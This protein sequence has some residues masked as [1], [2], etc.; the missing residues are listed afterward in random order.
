MANLIPQVESAKGEV[1]VLV[2]FNNFELPIGA[3]RQQLIEEAKGEYVTMVDDD[4]DLPDDYVSTILPLLDGVDYI[5]F[6][7]KF[8]HNG[9]SMP[10]VIHSLQ[11][12]TWS[13]DDKGYYRGVTHLNPTRRVLALEAGYPL[14]R[15]TGEDELWAKKVKAETE[16]FIDKEMYIYNHVGE[17]SYAYENRPHP[18]PVTP[19]LHSKYVRLHPESTKWNR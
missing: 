14:E 19:K 17:D 4:D 10:P 18:R 11:Y 2:H 1:E 5:G 8:I 9:H 16:H 3:V 13:Q 7:V 15:V 6:K 12:K